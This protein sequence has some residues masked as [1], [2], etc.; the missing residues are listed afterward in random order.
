MKVK[1]CLFTV[2]ILLCFFSCNDLQ[3]NYYLTAKADRV[4][5]F[6]S[7]SMNKFEGVVFFNEDNKSLTKTELIAYN[8][9]VTISW[10]LVP[11]STKNVWY[12]ED[13][14]N[15]V[16]DDSDVKI[17]LSSN[18]YIQLVHPVPNTPVTAVSFKAI[19]EGLTEV[20]VSS[21]AYGSSTVR[22]HSYKI[23]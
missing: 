21:K 2:L 11:T 18:D 9:T 20:T 16:S 3:Q 5:Q 6:E 7:S 8:Q 4:Y 14:N 23:D 22:I 1:V 15:T 10:S 12:L 19:K 17:S 13:K